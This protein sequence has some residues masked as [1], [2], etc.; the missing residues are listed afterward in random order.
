MSTLQP[1][2]PGIPAPHPTRLSQRYWDGC[3]Q[4]ELWYQRCDACGAVP[5]RPTT[6]CP[7]C[8]A[9]SLTWEQSAGR[10]SLYSWTVVWRPQHPAFEVPY[11][12]AIVELDEGLVLMSAMVGC[13]PEDLAAGMRVEVEFHPASDTITLPYFHP[14]AQA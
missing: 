3:R 7:R 6:I 2:R 12:P 8:Y 11:A 1:Q 5:P 4:G 9:R 10:G 14:D 13:E